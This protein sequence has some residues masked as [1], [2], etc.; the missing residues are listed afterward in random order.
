MRFTGGVGSWVGVAWQHPAN[1]WGEQEGGLDLT[2]ATHLEVWARGEYGGERMNIGVGLLG[3]DKPH[4]DSGKTSVEDLVLKSEWQRYRIPLKKIDLSSLKTGFV[5]TLT[6][7]RTSVNVYLDN[8]RFLRQQIT[9]DQVLAQLAACAFVTF[10]VSSHTRWA[11]VGAITEPN[12]HPVDNAQD[13]EPSQETGLIHVCLNGD[14]DNY[15]ALRTA[16]EKSGANIPAN[17]TT[18]TKVIP[19]QIEHYLRQGH[20]VAEAFRL[21]V[22]DFEGSHAISMHTDLAP[23]SYTHLTLPTNA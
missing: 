2:G 21:A 23:V 18:D 13:S 12:C 4:P 9:E 1:N 11:S 15:L 14:I 3:T 19:L 5:V 6:G 8:I 20:A 17:I 10:S 22:N 7:Q 16:L